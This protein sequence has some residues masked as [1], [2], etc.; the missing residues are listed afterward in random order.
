MPKCSTKGQATT[1]GRKWTRRHEKHDN[2]TTDV[3][4]TALP[5]GELAKRAPEVDEAQHSNS[6]RLAQVQTNFEENQHNGNAKI[7]ILSTYG[8]PLKGEWIV[9]ASG[10]ASCEMGTSKSTGVDDEAEAFTQTLAESCQQLAGMDGDT[11]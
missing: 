2:S 4:R 7:D 6:L 10:K 5:G 9:C 1:D 8:L 11:G 3:N